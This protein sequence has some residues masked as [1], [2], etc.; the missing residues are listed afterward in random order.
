MEALDFVRPICLGQIIEI[1]T[2]LVYTS[3]RSMDIR[4][5]VFAETPTTGDR[6]LAVTANLVFVGLDKGNKAIT[7]PNMSIPIDSYELEEYQL[8]EQRHSE[9]QKNR[10]K[11]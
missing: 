8:A 4:V 5:D 2:K 3:G 11:N 10:D 7:I 6:Y 1:E 9:R